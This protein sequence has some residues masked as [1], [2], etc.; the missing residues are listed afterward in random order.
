MIVGYVLLRLALL[1]AL[2]AAIWG[3]AALVG[4]QMP[5]V[6]AAMLAII[7]GLPLS[8]LVFGRQRL[9]ATEALE[10]RSGQRRRTRA[11]LQQALEGEP[12]SGPDSNAESRP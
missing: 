5:V 4:L 1:V 8:W 11:E 7:T 9:A 10:Q 2:A 6:V 12:P 3:I